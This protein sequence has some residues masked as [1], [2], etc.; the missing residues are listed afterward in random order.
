MK[1]KF[2]FDL[3]PYGSQVLILFENQ[4][5]IAFIFETKVTVYNNYEIPAVE[6]FLNWQDDEGEERK[7]WFWQ[8]KVFETRE[9]LV[10][11]L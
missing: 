6:Y 10:A 8:S 11:S 1:K 7:V 9:A 3:L 4:I 5:T 2:S